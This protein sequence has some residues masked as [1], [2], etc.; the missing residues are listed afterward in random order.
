MGLDRI[1]TRSPS[2][3]EATEDRSR[4][5][6][7]GGTLDGAEGTSTRWSP[8]A[9]WAHPIRPVAPTIRDIN[10][11]RARCPTRFNSATVSPP[12]LRLSG[13]KRHRPPQLLGA[14]GI[15]GEVPPMR[16]ELVTNDPIRSHIQNERKQSTAIGTNLVNRTTPLL[17]KHAPTIPILQLQITVRVQP[18]EVRIAGFL[19]HRHIRFGQGH[20]RIEAADMAIMPLADVG[21]HLAGA[22]GI[23][24]QIIHQLV[25]QTRTRAAFPNHRSSRAG[26]RPQP[27]RTTAAPSRNNVAARAM[28][29]TKSPALP[30]TTT[31][32]AS[33]TLQ[34][35]SVA[36]HITPK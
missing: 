29:P 25:P 30:S 5:H 26:Q 22:F 19:E 6:S 21:V 10:T 13:F 33:K 2:G 36:P 11:T 8:P 18:N 14:G 4:H 1:T 9:V 32:R 3:T 23:E 27:F 34:P 20:D 7:Q 35:S 31:G 15:D 24:R 16:T 17:K 12:S 28:A